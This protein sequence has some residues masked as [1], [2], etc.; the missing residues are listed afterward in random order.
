MDNFIQ[1][2]NFFF[3]DGKGGFCSDHSFHWIRHLS[4][5]VSQGHKN[6]PF[7]GYPR[8]WKKIAF[9]STV[10]SSLKSVGQFA[11]WTVSLGVRSTI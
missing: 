10:A 11:L 1:L 5:R 8:T 7:L 2:V 3:S 6:G 9:W 4:V